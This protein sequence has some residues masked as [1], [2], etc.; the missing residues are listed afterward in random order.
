MFSPHIT[1]ACLVHAEGQ[2][3]VVEE[4]VNGKPTLNQ[5]AGHLEADETLLQAAC[6]ELY[7]ETGLKAEPHYF[8][9]VHQWI[10][11]IRRLLSAF[12]SASTSPFVRKPPRRTAISPAVTGCRPGTSCRQRTCVRCWLQRVSV[13]GSRANV[14]RSALSARSI[15]LPPGMRN[16]R[17]HG[18]MC[19]QFFLNA[20]CV[21]R[22]CLTI[23]KKK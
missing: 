19:R 16:R 4:D 20:S 21:S 12:F 22:S 11:R 15:G 3:L 8:L 2:L 23:V 1:V 7:E 18:R 14:I 6:R 5:P 10:A 13:S 17:H 9:G